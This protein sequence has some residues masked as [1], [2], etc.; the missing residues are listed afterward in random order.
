MSDGDLNNTFQ[1]LCDDLKKLPEGHPSKSA[2]QEATRDGIAA[3]VEALMNNDVK[4]TGLKA[5]QGK[6]WKAGYASGEIKGHIYDDFVPTLQWCHSQN[7]Q[8][9][10]YSSGSIQAQKLLF[11]NSKSGDLLKFLSGHYDTTS[12][13]K[14][15]SNSYKTIASS[16]GVDPLEITFVSDSEGELVAARDAGIGNV[17]MSIRPGNVPLTS[18]GKGFP[19]VHSLLQVCG[20]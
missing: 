18:I 11:G 17:I 3:M 15:E 10:I 5:L 16:I 1:A 14:K 8:V 20:N 12:G 2:A 19:A 13:P 6:M 7:V 4:A 9:Y